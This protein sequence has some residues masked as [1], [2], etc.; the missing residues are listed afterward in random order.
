MSTK[1]KKVARKAKEN[2][3]EEEAGIKKMCRN[4]ETKQ[5]RKEMQVYKHGKSIE[6][7]IT[8][9]STLPELK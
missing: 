7:Y 4:V 5:T 3:Y 1:V 2:W 8:P 9:S 6:V